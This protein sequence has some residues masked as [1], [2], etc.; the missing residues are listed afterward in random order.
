VRSQATAERQRLAKRVAY[1]RSVGLLHREISEELGI[2]RSYVSELLVDPDGA[3]TRARKKSYRGKCQVCGAPT[4]GSNGPTKAP[5]RCRLH[6]PA[7]LGKRTRALTRLRDIQ[8][9]QRWVAL[10]GET[11]SAHD[12]NPHFGQATAEQRE[13][14]YT[15]G[16][17]PWAPDIWPRWGSWNAMIAAAG[18][19]PRKQGERKPRPP[20]THCRRGHE[21][22]P[23]NTYVLG[24]KRWCRTCIRARKRRAYG[25]KK[26]KVLA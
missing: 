9:V 26:E 5:R 25:R 15:T 6:A 1:L 11:P 23:E 18:F 20:A 13:R 21:Y 7:E 3:K 17:W 22:T 8:A 2:S 24:N 12:W 16:P 19:T 10:Y 4:D 14:F